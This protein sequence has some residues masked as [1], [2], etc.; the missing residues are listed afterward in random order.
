MTAIPQRDA[1]YL[2]L[3]AI[4][5]SDRTGYL[6]LRA[7]RPEGMAQSYWRTDRPGPL[8][9]HLLS[10]ARTR[11]VYVGAAPRDRRAGTADA[12]PQTHVLWVDCDTPAAV[13]ALS[14]FQPAPSL[15]VLTGSV[16]DGVPHAQALWQLRG[17]LA[18]DHAE[19]A[20]R[21]LAHALGA[22]MRA[23]DRA[24]ILRPP[25]SRNWKHE[26]ARPVVCIRCEATSFAPAEIVG[27]LPDPPQRRATAP[28]PAP[29]AAVA[30]EADALDAIPAT[31]YVPALLGVE[32]SR[33][34][35]V[36]CPFHDDRTPSLHCYD[37]PDRGWCC[38]GCGKGG[39]IIDFGAALYGIEPRGRGYHDIR[40]RLGDALLCAGAAA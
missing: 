18:A 13:H 28:R 12:V 16:T 29:R 35:K 36:R 9:D 39:T 8:A 1:A 37:D 33:D 30:R 2:W 15:I 24:R 32:V 34:G 22:D 38:F 3:A 23:T 10:A 27:D 20:N 21:R 5:G 14:A 31:E 19:R 6:E 4:A 25:G 7:K 17:G 40:R 26:P 11:D